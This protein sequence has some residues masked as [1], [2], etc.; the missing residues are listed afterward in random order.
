MI[1]WYKNGHD[2]YWFQE[3]A[4]LNPGCPIDNVYDYQ[5]MKSG[6]N[7][8]SEIPRH[9]VL[10]NSSDSPTL[11]DFLQLDGTREKEVNICYYGLS[12]FSHFFDLCI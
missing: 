10:T 8:T 1:F 2:Y 9:E 11:A 3:G 6:T 4:N 5:S 7:P 12:F